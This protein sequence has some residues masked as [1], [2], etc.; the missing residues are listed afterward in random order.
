MDLFTRFP[1]HVRM[2]T[3]ATKGPLHATCIEAF[4]QQEIRSEHHI[5]FDAPPAN[6]CLAAC[7]V[8]KPSDS[9]CMFEETR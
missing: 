2:Q 7:R 6:F 4:V 9:I 5:D 1:L 3:H 8:F